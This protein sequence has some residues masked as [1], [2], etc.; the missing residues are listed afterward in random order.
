MD[1]SKGF[2]GGIGEK[3]G[4]IEGIYAIEFTYKTKSGQVFPDTVGL[5]DPQKGQIILNTGN[6]SKEL[7]EF[8]EKYSKMTSIEKE[9]YKDLHSKLTELA[10]EKY[11]DV[12]YQM[13]FHLVDLNMNPD[14]N[15][16]R[17][18]S[19]TEGSP[20]L[21]EIAHSITPY[22]KAADLPWIS[23][24]ETFRELMRK[25][26]KLGSD[27]NEK[28]FAESFKDSPYW[29]QYKFIM[30]KYLADSNGTVKW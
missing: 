28:T 29:K 22:A 25:K 11:G 15:K 16:Y 13:M 26:I 10:K 3:V 30:D 23:A 24:A 12:L 7:K 1:M 20:F 21:E 4:V 8:E 27:F 5:C 18:L 14:R 9:K 2:P 19:E 17:F 6:L